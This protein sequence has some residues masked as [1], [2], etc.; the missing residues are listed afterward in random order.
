M[1][2]LVILKAL[3]CY[4]LCENIVIMNDSR[5]NNEIITEKVLNTSLVTVNNNQLEQHNIH[6]SREGKCENF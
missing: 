1:K 6:K 3:L 2:I 5:E 4:G